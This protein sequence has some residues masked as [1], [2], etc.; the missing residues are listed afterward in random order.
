MK[1]T[2][3][4]YI[5][6]KNKI[7]SGVIVAIKS[8]DGFKIGYAL[9][10]KNDKFKKEIGLKIA[11]GRAISWNCLPTDIPYPILKLIPFFIERCKKYYKT[12]YI[13]DIQKKLPF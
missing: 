8:E 9:C 4:Q 1:N 2:V 13:Y 5:R 7:P 6:K 12:E 11:L 3:V 10:S